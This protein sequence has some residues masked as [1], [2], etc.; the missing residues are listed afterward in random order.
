MAKA[1]KKKELSLEEKLKQALVSVDEQ[2]YEVPENWC[3]V[4]VGNT[5]DLYRG[6][7][8]KKNEGHSVKEENDCLVMRGGNILEGAIDVE[9]D[10]IYVDK[11]LI[12][13]EQYIRENDIVIVS[14]TGSTK[15]IGRAGI[16][17]ANYEDVS[18]G[19]FL[20]LV[21]PKEQICKRYIDYYFQSQ[22]YRERIR[23]LASGVNINNIKT[24]YITNSPF[25]LPPLAEQRRI[26]EQIENLFSKLD[27]VKE[28][29]Q[30][31]I[32][33]YDMIVCA[34]LHKAFVGELSAKWR[35]NKGKTKESW[36]IKKIKEICIPRAGYAFDS[37]KFQSNGCQIIRMGNLYNGILDLSRSPVYIDDSELDEGVIKR[38]KIHDGDI[39]ITLTGTKYKRDYGYA[40]CIE[41]SG[42]LYVNQRILC[43]TP[44]SMIDRDYLLYY[45]RS[46]IFRDIFFSNE[47]GG[48]NQGNVS[49]KFVENIEI[50]VPSLEE[51]KVIASSLKNIL[52]KEEQIKEIAE[53]VIA[54]V[55]LMKKSILAK[56]FRAELDTNNPNEE[57]AVELLKSIL[58]TE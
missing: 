56:A 6:V 30:N 38:A 10:N 34:I 8:Y 23:S 1:K 50:Q 24:E 22:I 58:A 9:A 16:S 54:Q 27:E 44:N 32:D 21:R 2:P 36:D 57:S 28:K 48:V 55:D 20:T 13:P 4:T 37:K 51:Q 47:T 29:A 40:V 52:S 35:I 14:S 45:L 25:P 15:V 43:L 49:S 26:V 12:K 3:W 39:L 33:S 5:V 11:S 46:N 31:I 41:N 53:N 7:S 19:A 17:Y 42:N 18:F